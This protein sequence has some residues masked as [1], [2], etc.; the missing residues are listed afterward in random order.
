MA[1]EIPILTAFK[2]HEPEVR[3]M[4]IETIIQRSSILNVLP[5]M[6]VDKGFSVKELEE[7]AGA[8]GNV[9]F[10]ALNEDYTDSHGEFRERMYAVKQ[11]GGSL[12]IEKKV[13]RQL[14]GTL[15]RQ[16]RL[17]LK[18]LGMYVDDKFFNGDS[19]SDE[20]EF[21]GLKRIL[22][23]TGDFVVAPSGGSGLVI[24]T[25]ATTFKSFIKLLDEAFR[26][27]NGQPTA[28]LCSDKVKDAISSGSLE[29]GANILG[30]ATDFLQQQVPAYRGVPFVA[31]GNN[32]GGSPVLPFTESLHGGSTSSIYVVKFDIDDGVAGLSTSGVD[33]LP[34]EDN[35]FHRDVIDFDMGLKVTTNSAIRIPGLKVA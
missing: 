24:N 33:I 10:R 15:L 21:D 5:F 31:F 34:N 6:Q 12:R 28:I 32:N 29:V 2:G 4:I 8:L 7:Q 1:N 27:I 17:R 25:S 9:G 20:K 26:G 11:L 35:L 23:D 13:E 30:T 3:N 14:P 16:T 18:A 19:S 22:G